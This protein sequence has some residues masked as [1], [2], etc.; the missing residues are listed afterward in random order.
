MGR[1]SITPTVVSC[2]I[3]RPR[4]EVLICTDTA[5]QSPERTWEFP[6]GI[7]ERG[8]SPE[9]AMRRIVV[10]QVGLHI[11]IH[12]GQPPIPGEF[13]GESVTY[14]FFLAGV[15]SGEAQ[16]LSYDEVRWV[17]EAQLV[18]YDFAEP[19]RSVVSWYH[20]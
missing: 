13:R 7:V 2:L 14:R 5:N 1:S 11:D 15:Q 10:E 3:E 19:F 16:T 4:R 6:T 17:N 20:E 18:E 8:E 12:T 9:A